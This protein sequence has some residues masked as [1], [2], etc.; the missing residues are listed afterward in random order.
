MVFCFAGT[1]IAV[2]SNINS[3]KI[4]PKDDQLHSGGKLKK[5][6]TNDKS[7][8]D[9][10]AMSEQAKTEKSTSREANPR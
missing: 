1:N 5:T 7:T 10:K 2:A 8:V 9:M 4:P 3:G 6:T